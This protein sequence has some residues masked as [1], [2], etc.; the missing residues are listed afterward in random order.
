M[1]GVTTL[2]D[3]LNAESELNASR[4]LYTQSM[5]KVQTGWLDVHKAKGTLL[6]EFLQSF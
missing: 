1:Q 2:D 5:V 6:S 4:N 3:L